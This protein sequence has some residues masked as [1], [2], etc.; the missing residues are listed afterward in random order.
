[1]MTSAPINPICPWSGDP[2]SPDSVTTYRGHTVA[3]CN[4][5][6]RDKFDTAQRWFDRHIDTASEACEPGESAI[7]GVSPY[8][9]RHVRFAG[10][11]KVA[12]LAF[13]LYTITR[14]ADLPVPDQAIAR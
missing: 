12:E 2:V 6:C 7:A 4:P 11:H 5:G 10:V 8:R 1:M 3:F 14:S 9:P 13:K